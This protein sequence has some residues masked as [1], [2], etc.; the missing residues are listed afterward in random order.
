MCFIAYCLQRVQSDQ[1][2]FLTFLK[3]LQ[4]IMLKVEY[5]ECQPVITVKT[6]WAE[7]SRRMWHFSEETAFD[8][9]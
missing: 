9:Q 3:V 7:S 6:A 2:P 8:A 1:C 4:C 5:G